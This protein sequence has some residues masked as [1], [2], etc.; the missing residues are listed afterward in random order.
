MV[1]LKIFDKKHRTLIMRVEESTTLIVTLIG[2][3]HCPKAT[4]ILFER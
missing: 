3:S 1:N 4:I 2:A